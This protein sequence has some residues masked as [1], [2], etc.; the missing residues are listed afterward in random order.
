MGSIIVQQYV[1]SSYYWQD[2][3]RSTSDRI[4]GEVSEDI[5]SHFAASALKNPEDLDE[6][7]IT[8]VPNQHLIETV[9]SLNIELIAHLKKHPE[10]LYRIRPRQF[11]E[12]IAEILA[13]F[14]W[15][16]D[17][18]P[19]SHDGGYDIFAIS[20]DSAGV[21]SSWIIEC[22]KYNRNRKVGVDIVRT[23]YGIRNTLQVGGAML[24]RLS[25]FAAKFEKFWKI[26]EIAKT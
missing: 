26:F 21:T 7:L 3:S 24:A 1:G 15:N 20:K 6:L 23:L 8:E 19:E 11:E 10:E 18:T 13:S 17:I 22:K 25:L 14:G 12:L 16:V 9:R 2:D 4:W 5:R